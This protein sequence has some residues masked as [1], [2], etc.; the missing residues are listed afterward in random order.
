MRGEDREERVG[1]GRQRHV[2]EGPEGERSAAPGVRNAEL[3][4]ADGGERDEAAKHERKQPRA[5]VLRPL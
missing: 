4:I 2:Q 5:G 3:E 1:D